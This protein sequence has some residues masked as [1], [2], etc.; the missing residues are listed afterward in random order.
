[1]L[2]AVDASSMLYRLELEGKIR[3]DLGMYKV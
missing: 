2:E 3:A 1:M